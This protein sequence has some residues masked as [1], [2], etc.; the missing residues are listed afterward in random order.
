ME[1]SIRSASRAAH[2]M[3]G[4]AWEKQKSASLS[5]LGALIRTLFQKDKR[6]LAGNLGQILYPISLRILSGI[7]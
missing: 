6:Q 7:S 1:A 3:S 5:G 2:F 4:L